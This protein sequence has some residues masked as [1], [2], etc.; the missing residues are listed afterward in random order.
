MLV[1]LRVSNI[2]VEGIW[3]DTEGAGEWHMYVLNR[4]FQW[5]AE[6]CLLK[7]LAY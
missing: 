2:R 7:G 3:V 4:L 5:I 1:K 6:C